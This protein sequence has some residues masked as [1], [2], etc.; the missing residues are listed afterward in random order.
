M[1]NNI[2]GSSYL[3]AQNTRSLFW[4]NTGGPALEVRCLGLL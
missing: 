3:D 2:S 4:S 1:R